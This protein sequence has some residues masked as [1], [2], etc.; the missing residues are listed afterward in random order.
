MSRA[1]T[2]ERQYEDHEYP[3]SV[4]YYKLLVILLAENGY[5]ETRYKILEPVCFPSPNYITEE[6][7]NEWVEFYVNAL[8]GKVDLNSLPDINSCD[9]LTNQEFDMSGT[10]ATLSTALTGANNDLKYT[11]KIRGLAGNNISVT[12]IDPAANSQ[13]LTIS[14]IG[15]N[16]RVILATGG[17]GA[18]T[19][20]A[21]LIKAAIIAN[22]TTHALVG[23][24]LLSGNS[25]AGVVTALTEKHLSGGTE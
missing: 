12:Y 8:I 6:R 13:P 7:K 20:T 24:A 16:I 22:N 21:S 5:S 1:L 17:G 9:F 11:S 18:I 3:L 2:S 25:G 19:S 15:N 23:V 14:V 4:A 10:F